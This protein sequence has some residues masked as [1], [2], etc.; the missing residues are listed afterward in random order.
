MSRRLAP[1]VL[2]IVLA[3]LAGL[4]PGPVAR[5][6]GS[7]CQPVSVASITTNVD[8]VPRAPAPVAGP[9]RVAGLQPWSAGWPLADSILDRVADVLSAGPV[10]LTAEGPD[11][12][13]DGILQRQVL[14]L[15]GQGPLALL[16]VRRG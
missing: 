13:S 14:L 7:T 2:G 5:A 10:C 9:V 11:P 4:I 6:Q 12:T 3:V 15:R 1:F 8:F 16:L